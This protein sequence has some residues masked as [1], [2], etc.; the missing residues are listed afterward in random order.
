MEDAIKRL[1]LFADIVAQAKSSR[2]RETAVK[3]LCKAVHQIV[4]PKFD[5]EKLKRALNA[6][7]IERPD[8]A[9]PVAF[10]SNKGVVMMHLNGTFDLDM[11]SLQYFKQDREQL[12]AN[13]VQ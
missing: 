6:A 1:Q 5:A 13:A 3:K 4:P 7:C 10:E 12:D 9:D 2:A 11:L 8:F